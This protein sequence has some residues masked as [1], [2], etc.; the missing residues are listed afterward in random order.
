MT[1]FF[2]IDGMSPIRHTKET[3]EIFEA[4]KNIEL[5]YSQWVRSAVNFIALKN[6]CQ[7]ENE[8]SLNEMVECL[9]S[10]SPIGTPSKSDVIK[11]CM[12][13][14]ARETELV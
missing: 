7:F 2:R 8:F 4:I 3:R 5:G 12:I 13:E 11:F 9:Q 14:Y 1:K 6:N 10:I